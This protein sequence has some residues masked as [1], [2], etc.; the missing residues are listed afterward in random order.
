MSRQDGYMVNLT[1]AG[2][3]LGPFL[4]S[5]DVEVTGEG[6]KVPQP[7][8]GYVRYPGRKTFGE[9]TFTR[10]FE[11]PRDSDRRAWYESQVNVGDLSATERDLRPDQQLGASS[12][13]MAGRLTGMTVTGTDSRETGN[14]EITFTM[15][16]TA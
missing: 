7:G 16:R 13:T 12:F 14:R 11:V 15:D 1:L 4:A 10:T 5:G 3:P 9:V 8:G 2:V 6:D